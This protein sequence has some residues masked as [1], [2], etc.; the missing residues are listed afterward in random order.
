MKSLLIIDVQNDFIPGGALEVPHGSRIIPV[1][2]RLQQHFGLVIL[3][4]DWHPHDHVSFASNHPGEKEFNRITVNGIEQV[5]WPDHC[6]QGTPGAMFHPGLDTGR[7]SV[8]I[9]KGM[10]PS[11][12]S[13]SA[14][15]DNNH[16]ISTG[17]AGY[18]K[19]KG[20][21]DLYLCGLAADIC[22][23][24]SIIDAIKEGFSATLVEDA[25][26]PLNAE[27]FDTVKKQLISAGAGII[28]SNL[29]TQQ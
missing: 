19:E 21:N 22:V 24:Y 18:L 23:Y 6:V 12:D 28:D 10:N 7:A 17:L 3:T 5:L 13:Y 25:S 14:F 29:I 1:I 8:V 16:Q 4:Q 2:N 26:C 27:S 15:Y 11:V 20:S 9:R